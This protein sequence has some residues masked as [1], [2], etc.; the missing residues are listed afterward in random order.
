VVPP[1]AVEP[2]A[3]ALLR[4]GRADRVAGATI[5]AEAEATYA[6]EVCSART[7]AVYAAVSGRKFSRAD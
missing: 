1:D 4:V 7:T 6:L 5:R 2:L 3:K